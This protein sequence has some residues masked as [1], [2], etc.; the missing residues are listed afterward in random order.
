MKLI[1]L[2]AVLKAHK[3]LLCLTIIG[4][5]FQA[6]TERIKK[7]ESIAVDLL[8]GF[9]KYGISERDEAGGV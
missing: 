8:I 2:I 9:C 6:F 1:L 7:D 5:E 4:S 3:D